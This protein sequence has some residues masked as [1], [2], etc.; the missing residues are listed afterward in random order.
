MGKSRNLSKLL[1][2]SSGD[3]EAGSLD[4]VPPSD[5]ASAL[6]T[7]TLAV[8]RLPNEGLSLGS[9][10]RIIN[11]DMRI[12]QRNAGAAVTLGLVGFAVD[13]FITSYTAAIGATA[14]IEQVQ[15]APSGF[16]DSYK[17]NVT[18]GASASADQSASVWQRIEGYNVA[19]LAFGTANAKTIT[20]SFWV[21][22]SL[23]GTFGC[24]ILNSAL[25]R[26]YPFTYSISAANTWEYKTATIPGDTTG[27]WLTTNDIGLILSFDWGTGSNRVGTAGAWVGARAQGVTGSVNVIGTTGATW[28]VT[29]VQ[30]EVGSVA[31]PFERRPFG[32]ELS[33]CQRYFYQHAGGSIGDGFIG[34][35]FYYAANDFRATTQFPVQMRAA[36]TLVI[37]NSAS[38]YRFIR[39]NNSEY[40]NDLTGAGGATRN[41]FQFYQVTSGQT[42]GIAGALITGTSSASIG[43]N[44]EL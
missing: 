39:N 2:D 14:T 28:Q 29:G 35:G 8:A 31:T 10:N 1:V 6:T 18:T 32:T 23:T 15:D 40:F 5:D 36:P 41:G 27:T 12:D 22:S 26:S 25:N 30:L 9:R 4:N 19:D 7:G 44:A 38:A 17:L 24:G 16:V 11:G 13:R 3:V 21:K 42:G 34:P 37:A 43:F 33:L 20:V